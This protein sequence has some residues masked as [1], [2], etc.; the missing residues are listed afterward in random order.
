MMS[1][2]EALEIVRAQGYAAS[3]PDVHTGRVRVWVHGSSGSAVDVEAGREIHELAEGKLT[4]E[5]MRS[6]RE[7]EKL[8]R[9]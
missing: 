3:A 6:R 1:D 4:L 7:E 9:R 2:T 8:I 5:E